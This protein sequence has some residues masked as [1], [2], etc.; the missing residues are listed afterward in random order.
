M[1]AGS[2]PPAGASTGSAPAAPKS[3]SVKKPSANLAVHLSG[4][5]TVRAG[6]SFTETIIVADHGPHR[7][8]HVHVALSVPRGLVVSGDAAGAT[9]RGR[10]LR[11]NIPAL[12]AHATRT[13]AV[14]FR[15]LAHRHGQRTVR[16]SV[17]SSAVHDRHSRDNH[18]SVRLRLIAM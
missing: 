15:V 11:W 2:T 4:P 13:Y 5:A 1:S 18:R 12:P 17:H 7:A 6:Q 10:I 8:R 3:P 9:R 16:A 14:T